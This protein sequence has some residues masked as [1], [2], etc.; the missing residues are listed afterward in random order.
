MNIGYARVSTSDQN[1]DLQVSALKGAGCDRIYTEKKSAM[2]Q[3]P[4][5]EEVLSYLREG[6]KLIIWKLDRLGRSL[7]HLLEII[8]ILKEREI[9]LI[10]LSD[11]LDSSTPTGKF[12]LQ[13]SGA[14]AEFERNLI[15]ERTKAGLVAARERGS[16]LGRRKGLSEQAQNIATASAKLYESQSMNVVDICK[17]FNISTATFYR[18]L[19]YKGISKQLN[20][21]R[22]KKK[23]Q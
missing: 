10:S 17:L 22:K 8:E 3:R 14:F 2:K 16:V 12:F 15:V 20:Y 7:R 18:Y 13:I 4:I 23:S 5:L 21:G 11:S 6:D 1:L 19:K 9:I